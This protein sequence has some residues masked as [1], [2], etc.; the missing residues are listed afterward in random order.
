[1]QVVNEFENTNTELKVT[2]DVSTFASSC[3]LP[4]LLARPR[5]CG[6]EWHISATARSFCRNDKL[7]VEFNE[8]CDARNF[9]S[10]QFRRNSHFTIDDY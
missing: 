3:P 10:P 2:R 1:M 7:L 8:Q 5:V 9:E 4:W 6:P